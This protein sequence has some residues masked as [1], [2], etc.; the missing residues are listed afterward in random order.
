MVG[1]VDSTT[2]VLDV[3]TTKKAK[4]AKTELVDK[5]SPAVGVDGKPI[6]GLFTLNPDR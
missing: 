6:K 4:L 5:S 3:P 2:K 1:I